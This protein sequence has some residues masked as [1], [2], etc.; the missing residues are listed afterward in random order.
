MCPGDS[1]APKKKPCVPVTTMLKNAI[2]R[3]ERLGERRRKDGEMFEQ[4]CWQLYELE[5]A[6]EEQAG[7]TAAA[8]RVPREARM[9]QRPAL[10]VHDFRKDEVGDGRV[11]VT[12][13]NVKQVALSRTLMEVLVLLAADTGQSPDDLVAWKGFDR[14]GEMLGK[15]LDRKFDRHAISQLLYRLREALKAIDNGRSL[16]ESSPA[17]GAR[18]RLKRRPIAL[19]FA[20]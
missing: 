4:V 12:F 8:R 15:R 5:R 1:G 19:S 11:V 13:D 20:E 16:I 14:L 17:L 2:E 3:V 18:V 6:V 9:P 7:V 10:T